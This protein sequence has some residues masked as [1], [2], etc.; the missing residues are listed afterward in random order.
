MNPTDQTSPAPSQDSAVPTRSS[1]DSGGQFLAGRSARGSC[2]G[3]AAR[4]GDDRSDW[5][6]AGSGATVTKLP[7]AS[8]QSA[9]NQGDVSPL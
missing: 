1:A 3:Q 2:G 9:S 4:D 7:A 8:L 5:V 6:T